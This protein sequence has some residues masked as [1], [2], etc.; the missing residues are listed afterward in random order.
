MPWTRATSG[1]L[2]VE[3]RDV[4]VLAATAVRTRA[5]DDGAG[6]QHERREHEQHAAEH[7]GAHA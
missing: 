6:D 4:V 3:A 7:D 1:M 5:G 2:H